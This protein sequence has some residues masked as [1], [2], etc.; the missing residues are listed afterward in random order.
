MV[1]IGMNGEPLPREH[2]FPARLVTPGLYG[3]VGATKWLTRLTLTTYAEESAYWT[4]RDWATD[5]PIKISS[6]VDTPKPLSTIDAGKTVIGG[7]AWAQQR[8][9]GK[10]EVR[11][12]DGDWQQAELGPEVTVDYW[13]QWYL[14]WDAASG[15]HDIAVR[16][17]TRGRRG[18]GPTTGRRRSP[19]A[20]A[21]SSRSPSSCREQTFDKFPESPIRSTRGTEPLL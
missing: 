6:R 20:P 21:A 17:T 10:V 19:T 4:D 11:I 12:D 2:G 1:A 8:G 3:F 15:R 7:I 18:A 14:P 16:A 9:I 13:R 5:A